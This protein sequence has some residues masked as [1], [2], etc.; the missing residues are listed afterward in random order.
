MSDLLRE[1]QGSDGRQRD[2]L[3]R[4]Q[5]AGGTALE[6]NKTTLNGSISN[7]LQKQIC[8]QS[9]SYRLFDDSPLTAGPSFCFLAACVLSSSATIWEKDGRSFVFIWQSE[10][11]KMKD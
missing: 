9:E 8:V 10:E 6:K 11:T 2:R 4:G 3:L 7:T 1:R 5:T